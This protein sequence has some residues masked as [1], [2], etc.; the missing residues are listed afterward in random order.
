MLTSDT[1]QKLIA[2]YL[3]RFMHEDSAEALTDC[4]RY[5]VKEKVDE[6]DASAI[7]T[8]LR[9]AMTAQQDNDDGTM[10]EFAKSAEVS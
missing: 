6:K 2:E 1:A 5:L 9:S 4:A 8:M 7:V 3:S 10:N